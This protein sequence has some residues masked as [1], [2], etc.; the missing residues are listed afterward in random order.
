MVG[1]VRPSELEET[2]YDTAGFGLRPPVCEGSACSKC[3]AGRLVKCRTDPPSAYK[4][5]HTTL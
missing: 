4:K 3:D 2:A 5:V 1:Q